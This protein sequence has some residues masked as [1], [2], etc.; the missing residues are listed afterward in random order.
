MGGPPTARPRPV[1]NDPPAPR[2]ETD[3]LGLEERIRFARRVRFALLGF[4]FICRPE[5]FVSRW[6]FFG[7]VAVPGRTFRIAVFPVF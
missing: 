4:W 3:N 6:C 7:F 2:P 1:W 5:A